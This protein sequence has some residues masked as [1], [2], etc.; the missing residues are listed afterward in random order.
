MLIT[1]FKLMAHFQVLG[2]NKQATNYVSCSSRSRISWKCPLVNNNT[3]EK[4][5]LN[6]KRKLLS[7]HDLILFSDILRVQFF[8]YCNIAKLQSTLQGVL[9]KREV[10][11][12]IDQL[13]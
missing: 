2:N 6:L 4:Y 10:R 12:V 3:L 1:H 7:S 8:F 11:I 9:S 5:Q 13:H